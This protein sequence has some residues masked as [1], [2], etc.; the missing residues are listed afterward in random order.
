MT[1]DKID[2]GLDRLQLSN[3]E[4]IGLDFMRFRGYYEK[5]KGKEVIDMKTG[6]VIEIS[7]LI[8]KVDGIS[9]SEK[10][11]YKI[12]LDLDNVFGNYQYIVKTNAP[13]LIYNS[14]ENN[15]SNLE[16][17]DK[18]KTIIENELMKEGVIVD[19]ENLKVTEFEVNANSHIPKM[20]DS[21]RL[22][23]NAWKFDGNKVPQVDTR[24]GLESIL[25]KRSN[26]KTKV[27]NK[28]K[29][30][31]DTLQIKLHDNTVRVEVSTNRTDT[32]QR[33]IGCENTLDNFIDNFNSVQ[34]W[35]KD[36]IKRDIQTPLRAYVNKLEN[37]II[38]RM[39]RGEKTPHILLEV[40]TKG[41][42]VDIDIFS[43][44]VKKQYK[45]QG[46]KSPSNVINN[47]IKKLDSSIVERLSGNL[48]VI[49]QFFEDIGI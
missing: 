33:I 15:I 17:L 16:H 19:T 28:S 14:N 22:V 41:D 20:V 38:G 44:A 47:Q 34:D 46:K 45:S 24:E 26:R 10:D 43:N 32:I 11:N 4:V 12:R 49:E 27:Y 8:V 35:Y 30:L 42:L 5:G 36:C 1:K 29:Q 31:D 2:I 18:L 23:S 6:E 39:D 48:E 21:L 9:E 37:H 7:K 3:I 25:L 13:K 40:A